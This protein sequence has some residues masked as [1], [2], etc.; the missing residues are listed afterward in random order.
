MRSN[1]KLNN[2]KMKKFVI[3]TVLS[4]L[5]LTSL[6]QQND[7]TKKAKTTNA[8]AVKVE[9]KGVTGEMKTYYM[10]FLKKGPKRNQDTL[11]ANRIQAGHMA[12]LNKMYEAG[13]MDLAGPS[14]PDGDLKGICVYNVATFDEAKK[15]AE[16]DPAVVAGRLIVE[17]VPW[18]SQKGA[19]L[20]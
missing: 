5:S 9:T 14:L 19:T 20:R 10:I 13:K 17:V 15:L 8:Q 16:A 7:S 2:V 18:Y 6:A 11:T 12:Y 3:L 4:I 1:F